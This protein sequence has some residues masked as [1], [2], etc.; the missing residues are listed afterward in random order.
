[1]FVT[2]DYIVNNALRRKEYSDHWYMQFLGYAI[3]CIQQL[4][5][6]K[7]VPAPVVVSEVEIDE[8]GVGQLP[9][10]FE[11]LIRITDG[12]RLEANEKYGFSRPE[13][14][15]PTT[16]IV[17]YDE[18]KYY[19]YDNYWYC[20]G[21]P[22][23]GYVLR[24][25]CGEI[26]ISGWT[27]GPGIVLLEHT[28]SCGCDCSK[29]PVVAEEAIIAYITW[30]YRDNNRGYSDGQSAI[31]QANYMMERKKLFRKMPR[32]KWSIDAIRAVFNRHD[33]LGVR[34]GNPLIYNR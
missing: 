14:L 8:N 23:Q 22:M 27:G 34:Y 4:H 30:Q 10:G 29:V 20:W 26:A 2:T 6:D 32:G 7:I 24:P 33:T 15:A 28:T 13:L 17:P 9:F 25:E 18:L 1:M 21:Q 5:Q 11:D 31:K 19:Q 16:D 3:D 12:T